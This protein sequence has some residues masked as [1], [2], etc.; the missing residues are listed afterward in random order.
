MELFA[1]IVNILVIW[2]RSEYG[3]L[4]WQY[5]FYTFRKLDFLRLDHILRILKIDQKL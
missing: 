4:F 1:K 5:F 2:Q 3:R